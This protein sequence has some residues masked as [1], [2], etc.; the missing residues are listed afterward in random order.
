M[1]IVHLF[2]NPTNNIC[3][4]K[5]YPPHCSNKHLDRNELHNCNHDHASKCDDPFWKPEHYCPERK[6]VKMQRQ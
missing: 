1:K 4:P 2:L 3:F 5:Q 6:Q